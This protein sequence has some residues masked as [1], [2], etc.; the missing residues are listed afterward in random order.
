M[1]QRTLRTRL[2]GLRKNGC[3]VRITR[4]IPN[5][6]LHN[7]IILDFGDE[8][9]LMRQYHD[10]S[11]EGYTCLRIRDITGIRSGRYERFWE[12][13]LSAE[14]AGMHQD[15]P[16]R[17][18]LI[19]TVSLLN[20]IPNNAVVIVQ[21]EDEGTDNLEFHIGRILLVD[22]ETLVF[23]NFDALGRWDKRPRRIALAEITKF[24][25]DT[26]YINTISKYLSGSPPGLARQRNTLSRGSR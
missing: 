24:E 8:W 22:Q 7:G 16:P 10:F 3:K 26:P 13:I 17:V 19:D 15:R 18:R 14:K 2:R 9:L 25:L 4:S 11:P 20:S 12:R 5:E 21:C 23:A 1:N 6:P